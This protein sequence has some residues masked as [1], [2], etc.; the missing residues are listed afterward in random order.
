MVIDVPYPDLKTTLKAIKIQIE[1]SLPYI[2]K[3]IPDEIDT[4]EELFYYLRSKTIY[5]DDPK[6]MELLQMAQTLME[7]HY[8][9]IKGMGDCDCFTI[10]S[11]AALYYLGYD[12]LYIKIVGK[13]KIAPTHIFALVYDPNYKK[14][15]AFDLTNPDYDQERYYPYYKIIPLNMRLVLAD[16]NPTSLHTFC[17]PSTGQ[18][19]TL[20][21][22][23]AGKA[24]HRERVAMRRA[25]KESIIYKKAQKGVRRINKAHDKTVRQSTRHASKLDNLIPIKK[26][27]SPGDQSTPDSSTDTSSPAAANSGAYTPSGGGGGGGGDMSPYDDTNYGYPNDDDQEDDDTED[28][29]YTDVTDDSTPQLS[30]GGFIGT[31]VQGIQKFVKNAQTGAAGTTATSAINKAKAAAAAQQKMK[32]DNAN[33]QIQVKQDQT[34]L[35]ADKLLIQ[36]LQSQ[37]TYYALGSGL[38]GIAVGIIVAKSFQKINN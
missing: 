31:A 27:Q 7:G 14:I 16:S 18:M 30:A 32:T 2:G 33:Y 25:N 6:G 19:V 9:G 34:D 1:D 24:R 37:N 10:L 17:N 4:P 36:K 15:C 12:Q 23:G 3:Y 5:R 22:H 11:L 8:W 35:A 26:K 21:A 38:A 20:A 28:T 29:D 13:K